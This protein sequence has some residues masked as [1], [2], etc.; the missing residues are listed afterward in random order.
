MHTRTGFVLKHIELGLYL[1]KSMDKHTAS[2]FLAIT[3]RSR[4]EAE[5]MLNESHYK[6]ENPD[7][8]KI[9][10]TIEKRLE[11]TDEAC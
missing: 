9:V 2:L 8:Y 4:E 1:D 11:R 3:F 7:E 5:Y 10:E 6:P